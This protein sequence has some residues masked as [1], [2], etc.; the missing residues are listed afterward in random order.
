MP[1][2]KC[3]IFSV[4]RNLGK[5]R[6]GKYEGIKG[7]YSKFIFFKG[8][9]FAIPEN[10]KPIDL[11]VSRPFRRNRRI[12]VFGVDEISHTAFDLTQKEKLNNKLIAQLV[13]F[14]KMFSEATFYQS[15]S[16]KLKLTLG[17]TL[18]YIGCGIG[19]GLLIDRI[20]M[21]ILP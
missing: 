8:E 9:P 20:L 15:M 5:L 1:I 17:E 7:F 14:L 3:L 4:N 13:A 11:D 16:E 6:R 18:I 21:V 2:R 10:I 19:V 12:A